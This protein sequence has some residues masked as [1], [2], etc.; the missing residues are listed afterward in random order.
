MKKTVILAVSIL[1]LPAFLNSCA[2]KFGATEVYKEGQ[3]G[4]AQTA[5]VGTVR[6][7]ENVR[8]E[9]NDAKTGTALGAIAGG[10]SGAMLGGGN[11]RLAT[12]AGGALLGAFAGNQLDKAIS[13]KNGQRITVKLDGV[14]TL[15]TIVQELNKRNPIYVG[16]RVQVYQGGNSSRVVPL[17]Y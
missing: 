13:E 12:G 16:Q 10:L 8:I 4:V 14:K 9:G 17:G 7:V 11:A 2:D 3:I 5:Q 1:T 6:S 15:I